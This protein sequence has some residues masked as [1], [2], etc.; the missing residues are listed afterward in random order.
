VPPIKT[1]L[2]SISFCTLHIDT[3]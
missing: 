2:S 1:L 3:I